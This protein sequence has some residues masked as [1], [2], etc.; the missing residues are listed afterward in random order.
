ME[1]VLRKR[2]AIKVDSQVRGLLKSENSIKSTIINKFI[3][4]IIFCIVII[5]SLW[6]YKIA[7]P[8]NFE[9]NKSKYGWILQYNMTYEN[10]YNSIANILNEKL[11][12][13]IPLK[14]IV[15]INQVNEMLENTENTQIN[16]ELKEE[17]I[18]PVNNNSEESQENISVIINNELENEIE[19][20]TENEMQCEIVGYNNMQI[21]AQEIKS[22]YELRIPTKGQVTCPFGNRES[23]NK[24]IST[25][26]LG[27]DIGNV[28]GTDITAAIQGT[29]SAV[30][31][32]S[33]YGKHIKIQ[34]DDILTVYAHCSEILVK[35]GQEVKMGDLIAKMGKTGLATGVHLHFEV[36]K[37]GAVINPEYL[38][39]FK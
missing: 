37:N 35:E 27:I 19:N 34:T 23:D 14:Q 13:N 38:I 6:L 2:K 29:V 25:F 11:Q 32:N 8:L 7:D 22:K 28:L 26:H 16:N 10:T 36:R 24:D 18:I 12:F 17:D 4:Q 33:I 15:P 5:V 3:F 9:Y 31:N 21:M 1:E 30:A 20:K 39:D